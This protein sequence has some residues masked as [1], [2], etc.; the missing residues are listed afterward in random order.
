LRNHQFVDQ[1]GPLSSKNDLP[2]F[3]IG[4]AG[5]YIRLGYAVKVVDGLRFPSQ[6]NEESVGV[7]AENIQS[8]AKV[9]GASE[10]FRRILRGTAG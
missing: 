2:S 3:L 9:Q 1:Q 5:A 8:G 7:A 4:R 10:G 6:P